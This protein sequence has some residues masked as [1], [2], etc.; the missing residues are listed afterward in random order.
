MKKLALMF[1]GQGSQYPGMGKD[2]YENFD[3]AK[4]M[5]SHANDVLGF[6]LVKI[7]FEGSEE[8]LRQTKYTQPAIFAVSVAAFS[9]L[10][11]HCRFDPQDLILAGHSLGEYSAL[12]AAGVFSFD[13]GLRLVKKRGE[14]I[15]KASA[16]NPG[17]MA[18]IIGLEKN[19]VL[20]ICAKAATEGVCEAVNFNSPGQIVI[21]GT[22]S[23]VNKAV[24]LAQAAGA[25]KAIVLNVSGP[26]HSSLM[27]SASLM[28]EE[29]L[30][31]HNLNSPKFK[32]V[33]NFNAEIT[34]E[35]MYINENLVKQINNPVLW[36]SSIKT[37]ADFGAEIF[38]E[39][40][41]QR[42]LSGLLR[43]IDKTKQSYNVEDKESLNKTLEF[44]RTL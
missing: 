33:S 2:L 3:K 41:P 20:D 19:V 9:V 1:P 32:F 17:R 37:M 42:V 44:L 27:T 31:V 39:I 35:P 16:Q 23:A 22:G 18:A 26:F 36:D 40:G 7:I 15:S 29:E 5:L 43:R 28:M 4:T 30:A 34:Q 13:D 21:A 24:E 14:F 8:L 10:E 6:D 11:D 38:I 12:C 25:T